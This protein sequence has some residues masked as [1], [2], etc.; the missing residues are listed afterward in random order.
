MLLRSGNLNFEI[1]GSKLNITTAEGH[2]VLNTDR[3]DIFLPRFEGIVLKPQMKEIKKTEDGAVLRYII[4]DGAPVS[5]YFVYTAEKGKYIQIHCEFRMQEEAV[6]NAVGLFPQGTKM[7]LYKLVNFR[8][9]HCTELTWED[10]PMGEAFSATTYSTDWQFAPHPSMLLFS[11]MDF[12]FFMGALSLPRT[13]GLYIDVDGY[14]A[15]RLEE[16]YGEGEDG[17]R[18]CAGEAFSST[19]Y[20]FFVDYKKDPHDV[21]KRYTDLLVRDGYIPDPAQRRRYAWHRDNLYCTWID[22]GYL[23]D[24]VIPSRLHEQIQI[25]A[26]AANALSTD[27]VMK[28]VEIIEREQ[29]PF[30]TILIDMGWSKRGEWIAD[31]ER[32]PDFRGLIDELHRRGYK[33]VVWWNWAEIANDAEIDPRFLVEGGKLNKHGQ[34]VFDFSHPVTQEEYLKPLFRRMFSSEEG[35]YDVDGV[36]TD[37]LSDK[38]HPELKIYDPDW[39]GEERYFYKVFELFTKEMKKYKEDALHIGCAGHPYLAEF[40]DINRTYD[41]WSTNVLEHVNRGKMLKACSPGTPVAYD[42][43]HFTEN[44]ELYFKMAYENDCSVQIGNV[45]GIKENPVSSWSKADSGYYEI[46]R[47]NLGKL[48]R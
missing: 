32:F 37:F 18:L 11:K 41:V 15:H 34:R 19:K 12:H 10:L 21:V 38:V 48:P 26:N 45:M 29:L 13:F 3:T 33:A 4:Q 1:D 9:R 46:L 14:L 7:P 47:L 39:R 22:Q 43:H 27:M 28:T 2:A 44:L 31:P 24:T 36:K 17:L 8:N 25:T 16:S 42:F 23:T 30:K 5:E 40:I 6:L 20:A 35:C